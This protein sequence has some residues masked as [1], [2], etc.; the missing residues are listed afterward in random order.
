[1]V[2]KTLQIGFLVGT[3]LIPLKE[4]LKSGTNATNG[5]TCTSMQK[6]TTTSS[7]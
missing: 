4:R 3:E 6:S 1:M 5:S 7:T 2:D